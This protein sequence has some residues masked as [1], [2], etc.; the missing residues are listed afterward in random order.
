MEYDAPP[1]CAKFMKSEARGR[2]ILGPVGSGKTAACVMELL[3]RS[4]Q[5]EPAPDGFRYTRFAIVR[6][7]LRQLLDTVLKDCHQW[8]RDGSVGEWKVS[9]KTYYL[10]FDNIRSEW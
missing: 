7:T 4:I 6:Q 1:T 8:L 5:Q 9:D 10:N 3:R 2:M